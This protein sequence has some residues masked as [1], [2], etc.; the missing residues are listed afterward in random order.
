MR[1]SSCSKGGI[2]CISNAVAK[3]ESLSEEIIVT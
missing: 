3:V 2:M 1:S